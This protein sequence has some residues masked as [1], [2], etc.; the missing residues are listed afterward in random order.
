MQ[1]WEMQPKGYRTLTIDF[2]L[3]KQMKKPE[4]MEKYK[5]TEL[6]EESEKLP[7]MVTLTAKQE[8]AQKFEMPLCLAATTAK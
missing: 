4:L 8:Y 6:V 7:F 3:L 5:K 2:E 1:V